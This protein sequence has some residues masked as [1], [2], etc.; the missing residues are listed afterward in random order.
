MSTTIKKREVVIT[1]DDSRR[2]FSSIRVTNRFRHSDVRPRLFLCPRQHLHNIKGPRG[3]VSPKRLKP[4]ES[5]EIGPANIF[6][7]IGPFFFILWFNVLNLSFVLGRGKLGGGFHR[8]FFSERES[9]A[10]RFMHRP[11]GATILQSDSV[12]SSRARGYS[13]MSLLQLVLDIFFRQAASSASLQQSRRPFL[14]TT[15]YSPSKR[16]ANFERRLQRPTEVFF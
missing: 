8:L 4:H 3:P 12:E 2:R 6:I 15:W 7:I 10:P 14:C 16:R 5:E 11:G 13:K 9:L 1:G